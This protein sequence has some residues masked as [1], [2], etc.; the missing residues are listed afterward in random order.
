MNDSAIKTFCV[1]A[2]EKLEQGVELRMRKYGIAAEGVPNAAADAVGA[3]PL[4]PIEREQR[5]ELLQLQTKLGE[6]D[7]AHGNVRLK[8]RAAYTWF[9]RMV[10]IRF[11]ELRDFLPSRVRMFSRS[12]GSFG[13]QAVDEALDVEIE[14]LDA[15]RVL[16]LKQASDDEALFRYLFLAQC[17]ELASCIPNVF[18]PVDSALELLLPDKL[19]ARDGVAQAMVEDIPEEDWL[20]HVEILG[21]MYQY[22]NSQAKDDFFKSKSKATAD[23]LPV[24]TQLFTPE[25]IVRYMVE[26]SLG[27]LWMLNN[28]QS[29]LRERMEYY[30]EPDAEHEDFI[31]INGPEEITLCDPACG[32]GHILV[33]A[34]DLLFAMYEER[35]YRERE[36]PQLILQNNLTG[37]EIDP[38]AAQIAS[39]ALAMCAREH[40]RRFFGRGVQGNINVV[41]PVH[42]DG[43][44]LPATAPLLGQPQLMDALA[45]LDEIGSLLNPTE[46]ELAAVGAT[47]EQLAQVAASDM[48]AASVAEKLQQAKATCELLAKRYTCVVANPPYMGS[49]SFSPFMSKWV[50]KNYPDVKSDLCTCFIERELSLIDNLGFCALITSD[51]C[52][53]LSSFESLRKKIIEDNTLLCLIDTRGSNA[54]PDVFDAN[55]GWVLQRGCR[56]GYEGAYFKLNQKIGGKDSALLEAIRNPDCGWFYRRDADTFRQI[57]GIP[58]AY[59]FS[60][61]LLEA[62]RSG[63]SIEED[64]DYSGS[65]NITGNNEVFLRFF[66]EISENGLYSK[67]RPYS[68]GGEFRRWYGNV[69]HVVDWSESARSFYYENKTSTLLPERYWYQGGIT[70]TMLTSGKACFRAI[71]DGCIWDKSGPV[72]C[73]LGT[74]LELCLGFLNSHIAQMCLDALNPTMNLQVKDVKSLPILGKGFDSSN[75]LLVDECISLSK[76]DWDSFETSWN[77]KRHSLL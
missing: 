39:L 67:W 53:Y 8:E 15:A 55:A 70:Y 43:E 75:T 54:H 46:A 13:S 5:A 38:R 29:G 3:L 73:R 1:Q 45:H 9:N 42:I 36:I 28:P 50:K 64:S 23:T 41:A 16:Q 33:Y 44:E 27:R 71:S 24:A 2:R 59:W 63:H 51:T 52:M 11:M 31:R 14:G 62:F 68:K 49:S 74:K 26:N 6:G 77:F 7:A 72:I 66:W 32:S 37:L 57:P 69:I 4:S 60:V 12:D 48:F 76:T 10:A 58:M 25:W 17:Q 61:S 19:M 30:I 20:T 18:E 34:F 35:G 65:P 56:K 21:W 40:D 22:Y 47:A